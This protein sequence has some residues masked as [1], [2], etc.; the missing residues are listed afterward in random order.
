MLTHL[1]TFPRST[2]GK[3]K[4]VSVAPKQRSSQKTRASPTLG[5]SRPKSR[6][7]RRQSSKRP[8]FSSIPTQDD[9]D[10]D[11]DNSGRNSHA[12]KSKGASARGGR[13]QGDYGDNEGDYGDDADDQAG[14]FSRPGQ[15]TEEDVEKMKSKFLEAKK[16]YSDLKAERR[17]LLEEKRELEEKVDE[18][19]MDKEDLQGE[20]QDLKEALKDGGGVGGLN[21]ALLNNIGAKKRDGDLRDHLHAGED[22]FLD[23]DDDDVMG[24]LTGHRT[25]VKKLF[26]SFM[27]YY[28]KY[29]PMQADLRYIDARYGGGIAAYFHFYAWLTKNAVIVFTFYMMLIVPHVI[30]YT[31]SL[32]SF[33]DYMPR[34]IVYSS[35]DVD[36]EEAYTICILCWAGINLLSS[37]YLSMTYTAEDAYK[38]EMQQAR[39]IKFSRISLNLWDYSVVEPA[40]VEDLKNAVAGAFRVLRSDEEKAEQRANRSK[41]EWNKLY[42]RRTFAMLATLVVIAVGCGCIIVITQSQSGISSWVDSN[43]SFL[44]NYSDYVAPASVSLL[45]AALPKLI[46]LITRFEEWDDPAFRL[47]M[48]TLRIY[49]GKITIAATLVLSYLEVMGIQILGFD[50]GNISRLCQYPCPE[51]QSGKLLFELSVSE[52]VVSK[53]IA[54]VNV[55]VAFAL[56]R[57]WNIGLGKPEHTVS[58]ELIAL[59]YWQTLMWVAIPY[60]PVMTLASVVLLFLS[61]KWMKWMLV[62]FVAKPAVE[63]EAE[64]VR[65]YFLT[66]FNVT[67]ML[68]VLCV[69]IFFTNTK[70]QNSDVTCDDEST[71]DDRCLETACAG[72]YGNSSPPSELIKND[73][74]TSLVGSYAYSLVSNAWFLWVCV[75]VLAIKHSTALQLHDTVRNAFEQRL[76]AGSQE[77]SSLQRQNT[78]KEK[79]I[80][81]LREALQRERSYNGR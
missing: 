1:L 35:F 69:G 46:I 9:G 36:Y 31:S 76:L 67:Y 30:T 51:D 39:A 20:V 53:V 81:T 62:R 59:L 71:S 2:I 23:D 26:R 80:K 47:K 21:L 63:F 57:W 6:D 12:A 65:Q 19:E 68:A 25:A 5:G 48:E 70:C 60:F 8:G 33:I 14:T 13:Q 77:I 38:K 42:L 52:F 17:K 16:K 11:T 55:F 32:S 43:V 27:T 28:L 44:G 78:K 50:S 34:V 29:G 79:T 22:A 10:D 40:E 7:R 66:F 37:I 18:L 74:E 72:T 73:L 64:N 45:G 56:K 15:L 4:A 3:K 58:T 61:F 75:G 41:E 54:L 49:F 24:G